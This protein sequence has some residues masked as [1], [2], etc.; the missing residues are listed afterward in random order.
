VWQTLAEVSEVSSAFVTSEMK[1]EGTYE[2][3]VIYTR[4]HGATSQKT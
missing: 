3:Q 2:M 1:A 4:L